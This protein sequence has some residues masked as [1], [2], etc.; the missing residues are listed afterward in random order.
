MLTASIIRVV[1]RDYPDDGDSF[2]ETLVY[3]CGTAQRNITEGCHV[4]RS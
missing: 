2:S 3:F 1:M 4:H